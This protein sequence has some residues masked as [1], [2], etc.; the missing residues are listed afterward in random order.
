MAQQP[1]PRG[2]RIKR[3]RE[4]VTVIGGGSF[5][6]VLANIL[7]N[8]GQ[9]VCL[10]LRSEELAEEI[11]RTG[12][13]NRYLPG[14]QLDKRLELTTNI[15]QALA[16]ARLVFIA[17]PTR[18][19]AG[20]FKQM[21]PWITSE[22]LLISTAKGFA[23]KDFI[24]MSEVIR[25]ELADKKEI[26]PDQCLGVLSGPNIARELAH[27]HITGSVVASHNP[28]L[29]AQVCETL[30]NKYLH[31]FE[32]EDLYGVELAGALKNIYA[33]AAGISDALGFGANTKSL[34]IT[35][36]IAEMARFAVRL[37]ADHLTF[38]GLAGM[39]DLIVTCNSP[40]SRN[41]SLGYALGQ[42]K[43]LKEALAESSGV[44]EGIYA[45]R[46]A[47]KKSGEMAIHMPLLEGV[48]NIVCLNKR[49]KHMLW[50]AMRNTP[51]ED[52]EYLPSMPIKLPIKM[53]LK[54]PKN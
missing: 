18:F 30:G 24:L 41:Y 25:Q 8:N 15:Q 35:R 32:N 40:A 4:R 14:I 6:T 27:K 36:A 26:N 13:N 45:V 37:N 10:R 22:H 23:G 7:A 3:G 52:V 5:G 54:P 20:V 48:Y 42:G 44:A 28:Q 17:V 43:S 47:F 2:S 21:K 53:P 50:H 11:K 33:I 16:G 19:F 31:V 49:A 51:R 46:A 9:S 39:G 38:L 29:R 12:C 34:L 1:Q